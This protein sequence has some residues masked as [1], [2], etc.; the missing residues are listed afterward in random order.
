MPRD[1]RAAD[2]FTVVSRST[3]VPTDTPD[4]LRG[5]ASSI[6]FLVGSGGPGIGDL[7]GG[8]IARA[9]PAATSGILG[10]IACIA[11]VGAIEASS[12]RLRRLRLAGPARA[13]A[14]AAS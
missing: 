1:R 13:A 9:T 8:L 2:T 5:R 12:P 4:E 7:R 10:G 11:G 3:I 14:A 6:D